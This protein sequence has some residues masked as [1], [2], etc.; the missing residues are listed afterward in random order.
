T[1]PGRTT[2]WPCRLAQPDRRGCG[3]GPVRNNLSRDGTTLLFGGSDGN[4]RAHTNC[5]LQGSRGA[6]GPPANGSRCLPAGWRFPARCLL[7]CEHVLYTPVVAPRPELV[8]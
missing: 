8:A 6:P 4:G 2:R 7:D 5:M 1:C 3:A